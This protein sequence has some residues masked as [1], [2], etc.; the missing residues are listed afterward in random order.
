MV[1]AL[2]ESR[3]LWNTAAVHEVQETNAVALPDTSAGAPQNGQGS[4]STGSLTGH[5]GHVLIQF[6]ACLSV[7]GDLAKQLFLKF[8]RF[9]P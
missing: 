2:R 6:H 3:N 8:L 4:S 9:A 1:I 5:Q 7:R